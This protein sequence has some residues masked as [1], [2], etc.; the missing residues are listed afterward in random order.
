MAL[1]VS[2]IITG[3]AIVLLVVYGMDVIVGYS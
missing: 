1:A 2:L 3:I